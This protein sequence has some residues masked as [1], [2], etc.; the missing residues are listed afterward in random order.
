MF[1]IVA[2]SL[3]PKGYLAITVFPFILVKDQLQ[4]NNLI[5]I[6]HEKIHIRQQ[7]ELLVVLFFVWYLIEYLYHWFRYRNHSKAYHAI[8][9]ER[10]AYA[11]ESEYEYLMK[12]RW[13]N[14]LKYI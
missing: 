8:G 3:I 9:F 12:R 6:N 7:M 13:F 1:V 11:H 5:L 2:K 14:F 10:E 4:K